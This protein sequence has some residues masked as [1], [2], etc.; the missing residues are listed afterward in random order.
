MADTRSHDVARV[1]IDRTAESATAVLRDWDVHVTTILDD[2]GEVR[3]RAHD[4]R[5]LNAGVTMLRGNAHRALSDHHDTPAPSPRPMRRAYRSV[6]MALA[7]AVATLTLSGA[8]LA[9]EVYTLPGWLLPAT[10]DV[11]PVT[12]RL[13]PRYSV[14]EVSRRTE[15][16]M[17]G[18]VPRP[19][20]VV[21]PLTPY[22]HHSQLAQQPAPPQAVEQSEG[23]HPVAAS[24]PLPTRVITTL[25]T[26]IGIG[27]PDGIV[28]RLPVSEPVEKVTETIEP[29][30]ESV[31]GG[32]TG[33]KAGEREM[34]GRQRSAPRR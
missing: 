21:L 13:I 17:P 9:A 1:V 7:G 5:T 4:P 25:A 19:Q 24:Q 26:L 27:N 32:A 16:P 29:I 6:R 15:T 12:E 11:S 22:V 31:F 2:Q 18:P 34:K 14:G 10:V 33:E 20:Q 3:V 23:T 28:S 8:G 30:T